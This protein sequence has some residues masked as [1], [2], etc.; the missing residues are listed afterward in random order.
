MGTLDRD[1]LV[2]ERV[3]LGVCELRRILLVVEA[4]RAIDDLDEFRVARGGGVCSQVLGGR[5]ERGIHG[6]AVYGLGHRFKDI[7]A[8]GSRAPT[9]R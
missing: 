8:T 4:I 6:Q 2:E 5:D 3:V 7:E 1:E 9:V